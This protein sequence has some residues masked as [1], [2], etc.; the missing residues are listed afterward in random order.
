MLMSFKDVNDRGFWNE[1]PE[2][3]WED[4]HWQMQNAI[5]AISDLNDV[6]SSF[7]AFRASAS[8]TIDRISQD[9]FS[10]KVTPYM[11]EALERALKADI[12]GAWDAFRWSFT[13]DELESARMNGPT[14]DIDCIGEELPDF[15]PVAS[16][17]N[18]FG[19]RVLFRVTTMCPAYC[20]Y[21][22]RRRMVGDGPGAWDGESIQDGIAYIA[23]NP[24]IH[25]VILSG[26]DPLILSDARLASII[27]ALKAI[28][29]VRRLRI[30]TKALTM[31]P[32]RITD[33]LVRILKG[34]QPFY[35]IGHF[36]HLYELAD[37]TRAACA[38]LI[39]AG[40]P[41]FAHTPLLKGINDDERTLE[42]LMQ[43]LVD[44]RVK[45]YYLIQFIPT[46]WTE[47]FRV[48]IQR[49][50]ELMRHLHQFCGGLTVPTYIVYLPQGAG[51]VP[52]TPDYMRERTHEGYVF[53]TPDGRKVL[54]PEPSDVAVTH[55]TR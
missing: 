9:H 23:G 7:T 42:M 19:N 10:F 37:E 26:G 24:A 34:S 20:R 45:P 3:K 17:T 35:V 38:R 51:K 52:V 25:E 53:E 39:D 16:V 22:F 47:H 5:R 43:A 44:C 48:P 46:K 21:C 4:W 49:G 15:N 32:Q 13:P 27:T 54:Y 40:I 11:V 50:L 14:K 6:L 41:V 29:H 28:P 1:I 31:M 30:D 12:P 36:T 2:H 33:N 55:N 8:P 18:F